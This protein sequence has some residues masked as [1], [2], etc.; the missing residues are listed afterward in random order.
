MTDSIK[1]CEPA[2]Y[3]GEIEDGP[4]PDEHGSSNLTFWHVRYNNIQGWSESKYL[5]KTNLYIP[6]IY[7]FS[8]SGTNFFAGTSRGV[9]VST[10]HGMSWSA[11]GLG[12][13]IIYSLTVHESNLF[14]GTSAGAF[15][16]I[17]NGTTWTDITSGLDNKIVDA[18]A[19]SRT[20]L[21]AE[22]AGGTFRSGNNGTTWEPITWGSFAAIVDTNLFSESSNGDIY[23]S[24]DNG[25]SWKLVWH[26]PP[27]MQAWNFCVSGNYLFNI[28][29]GSDT[30]S[31]VSRMLWAGD[32]IAGAWEMNFPPNYLPCS[33]G[34]IGH[35][36]TFGTNVF[37]NY[38]GNFIS[39]NS[40]VGWAA[41]NLPSGT[42]SRGPFATMG[43]DLF[44]GGTGVW[45]NSLSS[46]LPNQLASF[47]VAPLSTGVSLTWTTV[48]ETSNYGF[49]VQRNGVDIAL[50]AGHGTTLQQHT[51]AYTDNPLP[52]QYLYRLRQVD[53]NG[54]VTL[55]ESVTIGVSAPQKFA[56]AQNYPNPFNP[57]TTI[58]YGLPARA[59]V[60]LSVYNT[61]GERV[62]DLINGDID[63]GYHEVKFDGSGLAS[64]VYFYRLQAGTFVEAK[65]LVLLR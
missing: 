50:I 28:N 45:R 30:W 47:K 58:R 10:N 26:A 5:H 34:V 40:G 51:Y 29:E 35:I 61:L 15:R 23:L 56:L 52:G 39:S 17:N 33:D 16:S 64:G 32:S 25:G 41:I 20:C 18:L 59:H 42:S 9:Y 3:A 46:A 49:Y 8:V 1:G 60:T 2:G 14:A 53:L 63:A 38:G 7:S 22:T 11:A 48:S 65:K 62:I 44:V 43:T 57:A 54:T 19:A 21:F 36:T 55:S 31:C 6:T 37:L 27:T 4:S 13:S 12:G 24:T